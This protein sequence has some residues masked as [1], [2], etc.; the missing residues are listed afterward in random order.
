MEQGRWMSR[1]LV[2]RPEGGAH[3]SSAVPLGRDHGQGLHKGRCVSHCCF[4]YRSR[5]VDCYKSRWRSHGRSGGYGFGF[6]LAG[7][8][9]MMVGC[10]WTAMEV[11]GNRWK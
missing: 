6:S 7:H 10:W 9:L 5:G 2:D 1:P 11:L 8:G 3:W 4:S